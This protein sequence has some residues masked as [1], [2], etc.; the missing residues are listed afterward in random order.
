VVVPS[1]PD[2]WGAPER[3]Y[4]DAPIEISFDALAQ[5]KAVVAG[6]AAGVV[7]GPQ[8][9]VIGLGDYYQLL[10]FRH[11]RPRCGGYKCKSDGNTINISLI[12]IYIYT[13]NSIFNAEPAFGGL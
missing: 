6:K 11:E 5:H 3:S 12:L 9:Q 4:G 1:D 13:A 10:V 7:A 8:D 2:D